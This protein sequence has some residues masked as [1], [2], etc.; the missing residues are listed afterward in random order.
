ML[1]AQ[2]VRMAIVTRTVIRGYSLITSS[3]LGVGGGGVSQ[4]MTKNDRGVDGDLGK[5][6]NDREEDNS[7]KTMLIEK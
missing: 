2:P 1:H 6:D 5:D 4:K 7:R 3:K